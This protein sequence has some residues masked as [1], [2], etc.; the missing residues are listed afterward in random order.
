MVLKFHAGSAGFTCSVVT[1]TSPKQEQV[2]M[3]A[4]ARRR[5]DFRFIF[6][7]RSKGIPQHNERNRPF[8][9]F[10][11]S[12]GLPGQTKAMARCLTFSMTPESAKGRIDR[13]SPILHFSAAWAN[14][15]GVPF[16]AFAPD[17]FRR[18][19]L[20]HRHGRPL[21]PRK[22]RRITPPR[23]IPGCELIPGRRL[24]GDEAWY[25]VNLG[26]EPRILVG[27]VFRFPN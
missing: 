1:S 23:A 6:E 14:K 25:R 9:E 21:R 12:R 5:R 27:K 22:L 24:N 18:H 15:I 11:G 3:A 26:P 19:T 16:L 8:P 2:S 20:R 4:V 7:S 17:C 10:C 13:P